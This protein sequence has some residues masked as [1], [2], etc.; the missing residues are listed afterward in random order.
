MTGS[1]VKRIWVPKTNLNSEASQ[2]ES[3]RMTTPIVEGERELMYGNWALK[4]ALKRVKD[5]LSRK[6]RKRP[7][8][9]DT[10]T[11]LS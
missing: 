5:W 3:E 1:G 9:A 6:T 4:N 10:E 8:T 7:K 11:K 2:E